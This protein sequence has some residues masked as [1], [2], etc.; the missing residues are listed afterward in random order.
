MSRIL[1]HTKNKLTVMECDG[2]EA[3]NNLSRI[4]WQSVKYKKAFFE[5]IKFKAIT[6][7]VH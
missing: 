4:G 2:M 7:G 5:V 3:H 1:N 6:N